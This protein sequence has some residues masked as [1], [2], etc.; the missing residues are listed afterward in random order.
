MSDQLS[1][2][3]LTAED[4]RL[5]NLEICRRVLR[6][7]HP[8]QVEELELLRLSDLSD[9]PF[10]VISALAWAY[11]HIDKI[12]AIAGD[13]VEAL[14]LA[15]AL[16]SKTSID[17]EHL[18]QERGTLWITVAQA[19]REGCTCDHLYGATCK[20]HRLETAPGVQ[21]AVDYLK[22]LENAVR[23]TKQFLV[24][25]EGTNVDDPLFAMRRRFHAPLHAEL[26]AALTAPTPKTPLIGFPTT[27]GP[28]LDDLMEAA[29]PIVKAALSQLYYIQNVG[30][31]GNCLKWWCPDGHGYTVNLREAWKVNREQ[32]TDICRS[33]PAEDIP[34]PAEVA[35]A[36]AQLHVSGS[37]K[38]AMEIAKEPRYGTH[39]SHGVPVDTYCVMCQGTP[40]V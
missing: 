3:P 25:L 35:E 26:D 10:D 1:R 38:Q 11:D 12:N 33:R 29:A 4:I 14:Q 39:C 28:A 15:R 23:F 13:N 27:N 20:I 2:P 31:C 8:S 9:T 34:W 21:E 22:A 16:L 6:R 24:K 32:A 17:N 30:Y 40:N 5:K 18:L 36:V 37:L 7:C 19:I